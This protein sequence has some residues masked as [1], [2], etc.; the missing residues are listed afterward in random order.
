[1]KKKTKSKDDTEEEDNVINVLS[2]IPPEMLQSN[3]EDCE[4]NSNNM[5]TTDLNSDGAL[6][7]ELNLDD[8][9]STQ[10]IADNTVA[11]ELMTDEAMDTISKEDSIEGNDGGNGKNIL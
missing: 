7:S 1:M 2:L 4:S 8:R 5:N 11:T 3:T 9:V 6:T 10:S